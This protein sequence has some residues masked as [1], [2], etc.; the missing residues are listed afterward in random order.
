MMDSV[1][2]EI[3]RKLDPQWQNLLVIGKGWVAVHTWLVIWRA[4]KHL[5]E[6]YDALKD[7]EKN[8]IVW[9][10]LLHDIRKLG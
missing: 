10:C 3:S 9:A 5:P 7:E 1:S 4:T 8:I 6:L 2:E